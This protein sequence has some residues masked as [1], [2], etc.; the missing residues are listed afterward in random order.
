M[1]DSSLLRAKLQAG[2]VCSACGFFIVTI[3]NVACAIIFRFFETIGLIARV[4]IDCSISLMLVSTEAK[5]TR[6]QC[7]RVNMMTAVILVLH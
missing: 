3:F 2:I 6:S 1:G 7:V 5:S 4:F